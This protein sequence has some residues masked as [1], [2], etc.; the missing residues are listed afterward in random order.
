MVCV[1][2]WCGVMCV[3]TTYPHASYKWHEEIHKEQKV[4]LAFA[5]EREL[6]LSVADYH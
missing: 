2:V 5:V 1:C 4:A 3:C 6:S